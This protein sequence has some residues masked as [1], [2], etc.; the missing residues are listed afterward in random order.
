MAEGFEHL[1]CPMC[2]GELIYS[3][4]THDLCCVRNAYESSVAGAEMA[5]VTLHEERAGYGGEKSACIYKVS[6]E[7]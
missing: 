3:D 2:G 5:R 7:G 6:G 4:G 1:H